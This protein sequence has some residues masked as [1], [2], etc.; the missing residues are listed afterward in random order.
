MNVQVE[1]PTH[2]HNQ[3]FTT[4]LYVGK[5]YRYSTT[6]SSYSFTESQTEAAKTLHQNQQIHTEEK[7]Q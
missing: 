6:L 1:P 7:I 2:R 3:D 5:Q 4:V